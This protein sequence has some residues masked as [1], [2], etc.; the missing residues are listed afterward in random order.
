ME[1]LSPESKAGNLNVS[2]ISLTTINREDNLLQ[3]SYQGTMFE[4]VL[5]SLCLSTQQG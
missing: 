5:V 2:L 1:I 3:S 4:E